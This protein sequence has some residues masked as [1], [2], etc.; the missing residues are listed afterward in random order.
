MQKDEGDDQQQRQQ[1]HAVGPQEQE[2]MDERLFRAAKGGDA[3]AVRAAV[4]DGARV[5]ARG[6]F[7][8]ATPLVEASYGGHW[9]VCRVLLHECGADP[10]GTN[11]FGDAALMYAAIRGRADVCKMLL[12]SGADLRIRDRSGRTA[13]D[14]ATGDTKRYLRDVDVSQCACV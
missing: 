6:G 5:N 10:N 2:E 11:R 9:D 8:G 1:E 14:V 7:T 3:Y 12:Q 4:S 13:V